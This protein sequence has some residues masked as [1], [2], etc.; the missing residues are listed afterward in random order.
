MGDELLDRQLDVGAHARDATEL[1]IDDDGRLPLGDLRDLLIAEPRGRQD[2]P[3][4]R[5]EYALDRGRLALPRFLRFRHD[6][7][8]ARLGRGLLGTAH[9][10]EDHRVGD[11]GH[12]EAD[13]AR[14]AG[15]SARAIGFTR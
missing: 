5:W 1:A 4:D 13:G 14:A 15:R 10:A 11:V 12:D 7:R 8:V 9:D 2:E 6:E 3:V